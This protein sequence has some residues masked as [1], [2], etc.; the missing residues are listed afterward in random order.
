[1]TCLRYHIWYPI[2]GALRRTQPL[3]D[4]L[5]LV[6]AMLYSQQLT[7]GG[8]KRSVVPPPQKVDRSCLD[9]IFFKAESLEIILYEF[10]ADMSSLASDGQYW[11]SVFGGARIVLG[12][13]R[14]SPNVFLTFRYLLLSATACCLYFQV[15]SSATVDYHVLLYFD[16]WIGIVMCLYFLLATVL[17]TIAVCTS[18]PPSRRTPFVVRLTEILYGMLLP[19]VWVNVLNAFCVEVAHYRSCVPSIAQHADWRVYEQLGL[20]GA[21]LVIFMLDATFNRQPYYASFHAVFGLCF[22]FFYL[23]FTGV[24]QALGGTDVW[25]HS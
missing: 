16:V 15:T 23:G 22:C 6:H 10:G 9:K 11:R 21:L 25:G 17:S 20:D 8:E 7:G 13:I 19:S 14:C 24:Y 1:M 3:V 12:T 4:I 2:L 18:G 5:F